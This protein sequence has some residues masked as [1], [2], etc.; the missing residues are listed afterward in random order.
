MSR[1]TGIHFNEGYR[2]MRYLHFPVAA[3][4]GIIAVDAMAQTAPPADAR[5]MIAPA[6]PNPMVGPDAGPQELLTAARTSLAAGHTGAAQQALEMAETRVLDRSVPQGQGDTPSDSARVAQ[7]RDALKALGHGDRHHAMEL[8]DQ[9][10][11]G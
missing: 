9:A 3:L 7:I 5:P 2:P 6:L 1:P 11:A 4:L 10:L 8:I